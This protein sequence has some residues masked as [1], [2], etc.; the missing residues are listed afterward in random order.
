MKKVILFEEFP[1]GTVVAQLECGHTR[2]VK[3]GSGAVNGRARLHCAHCDGASPLVGLFEYVSVPW[4]RRTSMATA[5]VFILFVGA[6][7]AAAYS[8]IRSLY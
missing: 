8:L 5:V 4:Y 2:A 6:L 7:V 1:N 3:A